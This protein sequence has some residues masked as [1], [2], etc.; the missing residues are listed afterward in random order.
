MNV[1]FGLTSKI[2]IKQEASTLPKQEV[3]A[4]DAR[5]LKHPGKTVLDYQKPTDISDMKKYIISK[6]FLKKV[7]VHPYFMIVMF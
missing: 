6:V 4:R 2:G 3:T 7:Y 1:E 5:L